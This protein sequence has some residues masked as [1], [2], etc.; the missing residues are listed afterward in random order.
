MY[1]L[2][3]AIVFAATNVAFTQL[4]KHWGDLK[5]WLSKLLS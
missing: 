2:L 5:S 4:F 3:A 1:L